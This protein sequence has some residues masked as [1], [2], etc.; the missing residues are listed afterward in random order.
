M[1]NKSKGIPECK[2]IYEY[3]DKNFDKYIEEERNYLKIKCVSTSG[4]GIK[5][6][7]E[8]TAKY[9]KAIGGKLKSS[10]QKSEGIQ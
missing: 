5:E 3:I 1:T 10:P 8:A 4:E 2:A 7:A 9:I 6:G